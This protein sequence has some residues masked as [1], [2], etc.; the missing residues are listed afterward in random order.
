MN[1]SF[2]WNVFN[3]CLDIDASETINQS[4]N[5]TLTS[6]ALMFNFIDNDRHNMS[7]EL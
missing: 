1:C 5:F 6:D 4:V 7:D 3:A 2:R